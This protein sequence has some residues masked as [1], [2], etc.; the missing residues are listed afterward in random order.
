MANRVRG[1]M[2]PALRAKQFLPF[3]ALSGLSEALE[4]RERVAAPKID[5]TK[6]MAEELNWIMQEVECGKVIEVLY[7][8]KEERVKLTGMVL[9]IDRVGRI[10]QVENTRILFEDIL[11]VSIVS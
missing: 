2:P 10:L 1:K 3:S 4:K 9:K 5:L 6:D 8:R 11:A 7:V